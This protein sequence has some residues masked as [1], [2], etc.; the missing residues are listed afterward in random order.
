[1][2]LLVKVRV[3]SHVPSLPVMYPEGLTNEEGTEQRSEAESSEMSIHDCDKRNCVAVSLPV[4]HSG[5]YEYQMA[6]PTR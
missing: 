3:N 1:M 4:S 5:Y 2:R 6:R